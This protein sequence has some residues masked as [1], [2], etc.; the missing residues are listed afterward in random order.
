MSLTPH[1]HR[2]IVV[3]PVDGIAAALFDQNIHRVPGLLPPGTK[4]ALRFFA[5]R[6]LDA[7]QR[8]VHDSRGLFLRV[9]VDQPTGVA[10]TMSHHFPAVLQTFIHHFRAYIAYVA[11]QGD[12]A[13]HVIARH[14]LDHAENGDTVT[15]IAPSPGR[16]IRD[17]IDPAPARYLLIEGENF[18]IGDYPESDTRTARP[19]QL[20]PVMDRF[21]GKWA[22]GLRFHFR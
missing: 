9:D 1:Q 19:T 15:V 4:P 13:A 3:I 17:I 22:V 7:C 14:D 8:I 11:V 6:L 10:L 12:R 18:D 5:G 21:I 20:G 16:D 2:L